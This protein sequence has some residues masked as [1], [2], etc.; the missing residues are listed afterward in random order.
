MLSFADSKPYSER[1]AE[2]QRKTG[3]RE[4][5]LYGTADDRRAAARRRRDGLRVHR[6]Q[7]GQRRRRGDHARR[8]AR[9]RDADAAARD[10]RLRRRAHA[11]GLRLADA[12]G[13]DEPG[14]RAAAR[15]GR[16]LH[17]AAHRPDLRRRQRLV[18]DARRRPRRRA[19]QLHRLRRPEG[20]RADDP[21]EAAGGLPDR[22]VPARARHARPRRAA[23]EPAQ[24]RCARSSSSMH[25]GAAS[26]R[27]GER[28]RQTDGAAPVTDP[29]ALRRPRP[30]GTSSSSPGTSS[31]RTRSST[32][33]T[34]S[35]TSRSSTATGCST[36]TPR[37]SAA[38]ARLGDLD[39][40]WSIG[41]QKGHTTGRADG[42]Q[43][44]DAATRRATARRCG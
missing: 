32:S 8:R 38:L 15:G 44:R 36:R 12:D 10:R 6:R 21:P 2:A 3:S 14:G 30:A 9:A 39:R 43:L 25:A 4:G 23:R 37:S 41:H 29:G 35:T 31:G 27:D 22:R 19:G 40:R 24:T 42:A 5:A 17:L 26:Q 28:C 1:L 7:H 18:R 11:G 16:P 34:S 20:D 33:A 13:E